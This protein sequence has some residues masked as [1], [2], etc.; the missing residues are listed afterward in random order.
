[1]FTSAKEMSQEF[2]Y[3][4]LNSIPLYSESKRVSF[5]IGRFQP[6]H[7]GHQE[8]IEHALK[9]SDRVIVFI[10][11]VQESRVDRNPYTYE[12]RRSMILSTFPEGV[13]VEPLPD[14][15]KVDSWLNLITDKLHKHISAIDRVSFVCCNKDEATTESNNLLI[16]LIPNLEIVNYNPKNIINATD[17]RVK[18]FE[19]NI[20][21]ILL[22]ELP[23]RTKIILS[24]LNI[25]KKPELIYS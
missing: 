9:I 2:K 25:G 21:P 7:K 5:V 12:E 24:F 11:S 3:M 6:F 16:D 14:T 18:L 13:V 20:S 1:M 10:G 8:L 23:I 15:V 4:Y 19:Q 17:I 22:N